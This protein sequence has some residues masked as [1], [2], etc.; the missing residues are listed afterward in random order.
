M[1]AHFFTVVLPRMEKVLAGVQSGISKDV[2]YKGGGF[3]KY[4]SLEQYENTI[5][6]VSYK[7]DEL[8]IFNENK[9]LYEQYIFMR[10]DKLTDKALKLNYKDKTVKV[11]PN[12]LYPNIDVAETLSLITGKKI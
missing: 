11:T 4:Y 7:D 3:F 2:D 6:Q 1:G 8:L 12:K 5:Q 10:D 9:S